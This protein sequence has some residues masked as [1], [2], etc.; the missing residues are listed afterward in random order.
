MKRSRWLLRGDIIIDCS[1]YRLPFEWVIR[2]RG[3]NA[4]G[5]Y[6]ASIARRWLASMG[7]QLDRHHTF[8]ARGIPSSRPDFF[9]YSTR[10]AYE[11]KTG[12][13]SLTQQSQK[14]IVSYERAI[15]TGQASLVAY[16]N[17]AFEGRVGL[18]PRFRE[19]LRKRGF[20]LIIQR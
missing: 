10:I 14:Q 6:G 3:S 11:V 7:M 8:V 5:K 16:L 18:A 2:R 12:R 15:T 13:Q 9:D 1:A 20:L 19:E 4:V 17:V